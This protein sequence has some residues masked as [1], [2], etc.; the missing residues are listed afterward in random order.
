M[1]K[2]LWWLIFR[3]LMLGDGREA[4]LIM[5]FDVVKCSFG[6]LRIAKVP[7]LLSTPQHHAGHD[8]I[9]KA[10]QEKKKQCCLRIM[11]IASGK[12]LD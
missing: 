11:I 12:L 8:L 3:L 6:F 2:Q 1:K 10:P 4:F 5:G 7:F 9:P